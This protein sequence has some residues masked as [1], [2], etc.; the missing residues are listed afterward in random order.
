MS[1]SPIGIVVAT[2]FEAS[3][4]I[5]RFDLRRAGSRL[6][7]AERGERDIWLCVSGVGRENARRAA[8]RL[9][10][11]RAVKLLVSAGFCGALVPGMQVGEILRDRV[12]TVDQAVRTPA[13]RDAV[14]RRANAVAVDMET[15]AVI[16]EGTLRGV[17][18]RIF[19]AVSDR[20]EDDLTPLLPASGEVSSWRI[21]LALLNP[22]AW[23]VALR[24]RR[25]SRMASENLIA[26]LDR[27]LE[28]PS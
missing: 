16:E 18:I 19:R 21:A 15:Q 11:E 25:Q 6:Y 14:T 22:R 10:T 20:Y 24:L 1:A 28:N 9:C 8:R 4:L 5:R 27:W 17:P 26:A 13:E 3:P 23:P 2:P 7:R 12:A